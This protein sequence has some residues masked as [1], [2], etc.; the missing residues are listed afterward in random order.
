MITGRRLR[1][2]RRG[3]YLSQQA[4][5]EIAEVRAATISD[6]EN[7][8]V[9]PAALTLRRLASA[10]H[11]GPEYFTAKDRASTA[12]HLPTIPAQTSDIH[13]YV[14]SPEARSDH[15]LYDERRA[16]LTEYDEARA[17][18]DSPRIMRLH[19][20]LLVHGLKSLE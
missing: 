18:R 11:V 16:L 6:I 15:D 20:Q 3:R 19:K 9:S 13:Y 4:L 14:S 1:E 17:A 7:H 5:A 8:K 2:L 12:T 10:L